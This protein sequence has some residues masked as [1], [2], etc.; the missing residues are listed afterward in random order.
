MTIDYEA[1]DHFD[2]MMEE[3]HPGEQEETERHLQDWASRFPPGTLYEDM[4]FIG[5]LEDLSTFVRYILIGLLVLVLV[6]VLG[7]GI[8]TVF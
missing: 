5:L 8:L 1:L 4:E 3:E 2:R 7:S 6:I